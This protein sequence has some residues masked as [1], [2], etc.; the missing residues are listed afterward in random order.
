M[1]N[2][3][4]SSIPKK[5]G[6][7][8]FMDKN[9]KIIYIGKSIN[10]FSRV[11]SYFNGKS[12]LSFAKKQMVKQI[13]DIKTIIVNNE[14]ESLILETTL[15]KKHLPK[16]N[17]LMKD[18]KNHIY[19]KI[20]KEE[21]PR[22]IKTRTKNKSGLYFGPYISTN[23]VNNILKIVKKN[24]GYRSCNLNFT[25]NKNN[26]LEIRNLGNFKIPCIDYYIK[27]CSGPCLLK[28]ANINEYKKSIEKIKN[29]FKGNLKETQENL[30]KKMEFYAKN[31]EFEKAGNIKKELEAIQILATKQIVSGSIKGNYDIINFCE[32]FDNFY[33]GLIEI[34]NSKIIG[35]YS[36]EVQNNL[37]ESKENIIISFIE[38]KLSLYLSEN[39]SSIPIFILPNIIKKDGISFNNI[40]IETPSIG[41]KLDLLKLC[42]KNIYEFAMKKHLASLSTKRYTKQNMKNLLHI[43]G[44]NRINKE[45]TFECNDISHLS[46]THTV[47][48][49]SIII[50]GKSD[51]SKYKKF[52][53]KNLKEG[54]I[55]DFD[56]MREIITRRIKEIKKNGI[57]PD[58]IIID[59]GKG[60]LSSVYEIIKKSGI[61]VQVVSIAKR[62][63]ELF[64]PN[65]PNPFILKKDSLELKLIQKIRDEAHRFAITFNR[66][67]RNKSMKKNILESLPGI[68]PKTRKKILSIF[69]SIEGL[70]K[71]SSDDLEK[72]LSN[73][74]IKILENHGLINN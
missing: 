61:S 38:G 13:V 71:A 17:I 9:G 68:G 21:I 69:G 11:N 52:R 74:V 56:S 15:I 46:G 10:L 6:V 27:R 34:R 16:Y 45:I 30:I 49:R 67:S 60:Q 19:I 70:E 50:N 63:E 1:I 33:I 28:E 53:I 23:Y 37:K 4:L 3:D 42:Y 12:K 55:D 57:I 7:Y 25:L 5:P 39:G 62:E 36:Y 54:K 51:T 41:N 44:Y 32:K 8:L 24:F 58:L 14:T 40:K 65:N 22:I 59:G 47:A 73:N 72:N 26:N 31:L 29:I 48:S 2:K 43:L 35:Y 66:D 18:G 64:V 20:T